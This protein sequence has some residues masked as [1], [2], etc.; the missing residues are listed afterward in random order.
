MAEPRFFGI[1]NLVEDQG[2]QWEALST[3]LFD[4]EDQ[5]HGP[6]DVPG[7]VE[8]RSIGSGSA[9]RRLGYYGSNDLKENIHREDEAGRIVC[10]GVCT[11]IHGAPDGSAQYLSHCPAA[12][13]D[14][15]CSKLGMP[16]AY[17]ADVLMASV[18]PPTAIV[19]S[20][21]GLHALWRF[22]SSINLWQHED[23]QPTPAEL[24]M[25]L[26]NLARICH[27]DPAVCD[28]A[29]VLR[30]PGTYNRKPEILAQNGNQPYLANVH[31][32]RPNAGYSYEELR[33]KTDAIAGPLFELQQKHQPESRCNDATQKNDAGGISARTTESLAGTSP[34]QPHVNVEE[35]LT[36]MR[37]QGSGDTG[38]HLTQLQ[39]TAALVRRGWP[40]D[41][42]L[43][44]VA[45][46]TR[47]AAGLHGQQWD[48]QKEENSIRNMIESARRK[49]GVPSV[50]G[51]QEPRGNAADMQP[52]RIEDDKSHRKTHSAANLLLKLAEDAE[53][54]HSQDRRAYAT[55]PV[56]SHRQT[57]EVDGEVFADWL[58]SRY[59]HRRAAAVA[60]EDMKKAVATLSARARFDGQ[61]HEVF[62]RTAHVDG[63]IYVDLCNLTGQVVEVSPEGWRVLDVSPVK[64]RRTPG[65][66]ALPFPVRGGDINLLFKHVN[67][68][69]A[70]SRVLTVAWLLAALSGRKPFPILAVSGEQGAAKS[71]FCEMLRDL[72][73]P[74]VAPLR[75]LPRD[76]RELFIAASNCHVLSF[77]NVSSIPH[78]LSDGLCRI[79]TGGGLSARKLY[80]DENEKLFSLARPIMLNGIGDALERPDLLD[81][82]IRISLL[83]IPDERRRPEREIWASFR[84][85]APQILGALFDGLVAG[86][87]RLDVIE[88]GKLPRM[89]D[90][91][92]LASACEVAYWPSGTFMRAYD[93]NREDATAEALHSD[94][95]A[96]AIVTLMD[97]R[98]TWEGTASQLDAVLA[99]NSDGASVR[100]I[101]W[102]KNIRQFGIA[103]RRV[104]PLLRQHGIAIDMRRSG[105]D[106]QRLITLCSQR[107]TAHEQAVSD[108]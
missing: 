79:A 20:G 88:L 30:V 31:E 16:K 82:A 97:G 108:K 106:R 6:T 78:L 84:E 41:Q 43:E 9:R 61:R 76:E 52:G 32:L 58:A 72:V 95:L 10:Y 99:G 90:F 55:V 54:F 60:P 91:A 5:G 105:K 38:I 28:L 29:R 21:G 53:L 86:L 94:P 14:I 74:S 87:G 37:H 66:K 33:K 13:A 36:R 100:D 44:R 71:T 83:A 45:T 89:A 75:S 39:V 12:W 25:L 23:A 35:R 85:N 67:L 3:H 93:E 17:C 11:R 92:Y 15:D 81:R 7:V 57:L 73:D 56:G 48:W 8:I 47:R 77:D 59:Y 49:F 26:R 1:D 40:E 80:S 103:V 63:R 4:R 50:L 65:M 62:V 51:P 101:G 107:A 24:V 102:P 46:A 22:W 69:D 2:D 19:D 42:I 27:G 104:A 68:P 18:I 64:F 96:K 34:N 70:D 98:P